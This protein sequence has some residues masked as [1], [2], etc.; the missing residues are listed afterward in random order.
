MRSHRL[1]AASVALACLALAV[2]GCAAIPT[3]GTVQAGDPP[4]ADP[5]VDFD[6][7]VPSPAV[8]ATQKEIL[9]GFI[10]AAQSP[11][12]NY[13]VAREYLTETFANEWQADAGA[14]IDVLADREIG[15]IDDMT[16]RVDATPA[17]ILKDNGQYE[18]P[19]S[20]TPI[21]FD[22]RFEQV[23]GQWRIAS[24]PPGLL[25]DEISFTSVFRDYTLY[26]FDPTYRYLVPAGRHVGVP[27]GRPAR[28]G[29]S[30]GRRSGGE[31]VPRRGSVRRLAHGS[32]DAGTTARESPLGAQH[33]RGRAHAERRR[34]ESAAAS[35]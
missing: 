27:R 4:P 6:I 32:A 1:L 17:A 5:P 24:A 8:D 10:L 12:N 13:R 30:P 34:S 28:A 9:D 33:R 21:P 20:R 2:T 23:D 3:T 15:V 35:G 26:F 7:L 14:T 19:D 22:Y 11:R 18:D 31:R 29:R 25:I 16:L